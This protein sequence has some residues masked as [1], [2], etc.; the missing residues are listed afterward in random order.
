VLLLVVSLVLGEPFPDLRNL[1][2]SFVAGSVGSLGLLALYRAMTV[3]EMGIASP[4]SAV[5]TAGVPVIFTAF[6]LGLPSDLQVA[7]FVLALV[8]VWLVSRPTNSHTSTQ[9]LFWAFLSSLGFAGFKIL[10][11]LIPDGAVWW[12]LMWAR[13]GGLVCMVAMVL[14]SR[15]PAHISRAVLPLALLSGVLDT[16]GNAGF[17]LSAQF[18]RLDSAS[19]LSALYPAV[20]AAMAFIVLRERLKPTQLGGVVL[21]LVA[22]VMISAG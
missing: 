18:G 15:I 10:M 17:L 3:G 11:S 2:L 19:V 8:G 4:A 14:L 9:T 22:I 20:T 13:T 7:G 1:A 6:T 16:V 12:P 5:L 21:M